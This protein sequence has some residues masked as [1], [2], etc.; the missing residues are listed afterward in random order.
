M[1]SHRWVHREVHDLA[2]VIASAP[3]IVGGA[4]SENWIDRQQCQRWFQGA[5][6]WLLEQDKAP[7]LL[8]EY[9][10]TLLD[11]RLGSRF[12][13]LLAWWLEA[14]PQLELMH[15]NLAV[16]VPGR[17]LGEFDFIIR[18]RLTGRVIH[19]EVAVKFYLA[20]ADA[21]LRTVYYGPDLRDRLDNKLRHM[22]NHQM[23]LAERAEVHDWLR[24][25]GLKI[26]SHCGLVKGRLFYNHK[27]FDR[28]PLDENCIDQGH[29]RGEWVSMSDFPIRFKAS[30][31]DWTV[32]D[33]S[34]WFAP[35]TVGDEFPWLTLQQLSEL[36]VAKGLY[37]PV[38][39]AGGR[40]GVER[41]RV[42]LVPDD[43]VACDN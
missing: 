19:W 29:E 27:Y 6:A 10:R 39:L 32:L 1:K 8:Q 22:V 2:W 33:K 16:R 43:W 17:T 3:M 12:E 31:L 20:V 13:A 36:L 26:D 28:S 40:E 23:S 11:K 18:D 14:N 30:G 37:R 34:F 38:C 42:F 9:L 25:R 35:V 21:Q 7:G 24:Q 15:R 5:S 4:F 41:R